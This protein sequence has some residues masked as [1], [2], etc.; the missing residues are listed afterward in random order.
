ML[1]AAKAA[2]RREEG[3]EKITESRQ[4]IRQ[5]AAANLRLQQKRS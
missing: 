4:V 5:V 3:W 1:I 2:S